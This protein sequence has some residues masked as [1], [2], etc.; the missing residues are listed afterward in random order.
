MIVITYQREKC[1]GCNYCVEMDFENWRMTKKD[2]K[3]TLLGSVNRKGFH[4]LRL[5]SGD[6]DLHDR[7]AK[8][9]PVDVIKVRLV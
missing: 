2:G 7:V 9:C 3:S 8:V 6:I 1:I 4:T 5:N